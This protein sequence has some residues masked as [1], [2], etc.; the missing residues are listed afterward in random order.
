MV[1]TLNT[2]PIVDTNSA[3]TNSN[4]GS[5]TS[6]FGSSPSQSTCNTIPIL[7]NSA[8]SVLASTSLPCFSSTNSE[9]CRFKPLNLP[10]WNTD[11][12][13]PAFLQL[14]ENSMD[15]ATDA[16]MSSTVVNCL[17]PR[18]LDLVMPHFPGTKWTYKEA[19]TAIIDEFCS[20]DSIV[21]A[22]TD[23]LNISIRLDETLI[24]F[25]DRFYH[26]AQV[27]LGSGAMTHYDSQI[28]LLNAI[29]PH[30]EL[31]HSMLPAL[32]SNFTTSRM[33]ENFYCIS[34]TYDKIMLQ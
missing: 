14:F 2:L 5:Q 22:K 28:A 26:S 20:Q 23:F 27:L 8:E 19:K 34:S 10:R 11:R 32:V 29:K 31:H 13:I 4:T 30:L 25:A 17:D 7:E 9:F 33:T 15:G 12:N 3:A 6:Q 1:A 16:E 21:S 24:E 18:S